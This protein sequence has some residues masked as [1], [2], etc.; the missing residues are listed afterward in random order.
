[1]S[2]TA[3][4]L[5]ILDFATGLDLDN[6]ADFDIFIRLTNPNLAVDDIRRLPLKFKN[7]LRK[8][9][10]SIVKMGASIKERDHIVDTLY[11]Y[12]DPSVSEEELKGL[13]PEGRARIHGSFKRQGGTLKSE[14]A[15]NGWLDSMRSDYEDEY[16]KH[17]CP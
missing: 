3:E 14:E 4:Q 7:S 13:G 2:L 17:I 10:K 12:V 11:K 5:E 1:M 8:S 16:I 6:E 9:V 15:I